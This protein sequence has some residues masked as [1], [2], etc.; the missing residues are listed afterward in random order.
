MKTKLVT[1]GLLSL[2][3]FITSCS[4]DNTE[5][6]PSQD[7]T[8]IEKSISGSSNLDVSDLFNVYVNFSDSEESLIVKANDNLHQY[9]Q[10]NDNNNRLK[11][12]LRD[13]INII[14]KGLV[15]NV[16]IT[17]KNISNFNLNG[18]VNVSLENELY[19]DEVNIDINGA[20]NFRGYISTNDLMVRLT[21]AS[22]INLSGSS[23]TLD[24][25]SDGASEFKNYSFQAENFIADLS[26]ASNAYTSVSG[27][28]RVKAVG[29]SN[30]F[31]KGTGTVHSQSLQG[32]SEIKKMD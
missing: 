21:G 20:S 17:T 10:I 22:N 9:I 5:I 11:I 16:Y 25:T 30:V 24:I 26:G 13:N 29:A 1:I 6:L 28:L 19:T 23:N 15:L 4:K 3:I 2:V 32:A 7:V 18:A 8:T 31:Y 14:G 27:S 12:D